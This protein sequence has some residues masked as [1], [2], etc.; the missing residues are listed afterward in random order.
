M[1]YEVLISCDREQEKR[2]IQAIAEQQQVLDL[3]ILVVDEEAL[4]KSLEKSLC[5]KINHFRSFHATEREEGDHY[6]VYVLDSFFPKFIIQRMR[7]YYL[8]APLTEASVIDA[9]HHIVKDH[10]QWNTFSFKIGWER[11]HVPVDRI[12]YIESRARTLHVVGE[13]FSY[14]YYG[15]LEDAYTHLIDYQFIRIHHSTIINPFYVHCLNSDELEL[16]SGK[17]L[18]IS[19]RYKNNVRHLLGYRKG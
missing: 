8:L 17:R 9:I 18:S 5:I 6:Q 7:T 12:H 16:L 2:L 10:Q 15:K 4:N 14:R 13:D 3:D 1:A 19:R 11:I